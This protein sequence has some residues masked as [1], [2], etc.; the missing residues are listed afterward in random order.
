MR[1]SALIDIHQQV[2][3]CVLKIRVPTPC[4]QVF[5]FSRDALPMVQ[6][7]CGQGPDFST[8]VNYRLLLHRSDLGKPSVEAL[9]HFF[10]ALLFQLVQRDIHVFGF[11]GVVSLLDI[12]KQLSELFIGCGCQ[13][14]C[15]FRPD[16]SLYRPPKNFQLV[17]IGV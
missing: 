3:E 16:L 6:S 4:Q 1:G 5:Q 12:F 14:V 7:V 2:Y 17:S 15:Y 9:D 10:S 8:P 13:Y 11:E